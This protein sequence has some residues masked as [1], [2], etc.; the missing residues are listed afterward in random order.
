ML[1]I[2][3]VRVKL[4]EARSDRL[5]AFCSITIDDDFVVHDL[6]VIAGKKG[7]FVAMPSR[8]LTDNCPRCGGKNHLRAQYCN[9]CGN[10]LD[11][12]RAGSGKLH[13]DVAHPIN[14]PC[15]KHI[16][17]AVLEA[18]DEEI[19]RKEQ[20]LEPEHIYL[21]DDLDSLT[22]DESEETD[23]Y[24]TP[25]WDDEDYED[26]EEEEEA[27]GVEEEPEP[28]PTPE[29]EE[30]ESG[31]E[32]EIPAEDQITPYGE[33]GTEP[34]GETAP[35]FGEDVDWQRHTGEEDEEEME[36]EEEIS[37]FDVGDILEEEEPEPEVE[38]EPEPP[39]EDEEEPEPEVED[40]EEEE[41]DEE[42]EPRG[43]SDGIF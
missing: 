8:K 2:T 43:F 24:E 22:E 19:S 36:E 12:D 37:P 33:K 20:G 11:E 9:D 28:E 32:Q 6:R 10:K 40:E 4:M 42:E 38:E 25:D 17:S 7:R 14:T 34:A 1:N 39:A 23:D 27:F 35:Q 21:E 5:R 18:Y 26:E 30:E 3:E 41:E 13:V 16:Q 15:R 29:E 31:P